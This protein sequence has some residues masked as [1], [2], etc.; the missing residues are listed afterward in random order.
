MSHTLRDLHASCTTHHVK[1]VVI[2][3]TDN[4]A[5][6]AWN[7]F[8]VYATSPD[9]E[10][11]LLVSQTYCG[12]LCSR[13]DLALAQELFEDAALVPIDNNALVRVQ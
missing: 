12:L 8:P 6:G 10:A 4:L 1:V 13:A 3:V 7:C 2:I 5:P 11:V 9:D